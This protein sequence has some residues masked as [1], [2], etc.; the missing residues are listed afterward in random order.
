MVTKM[1]QFEQSYE[2]P[3]AF[4]KWWDNYKVEGNWDKTAQQAVKE[5]F[6]DYH[7]S[8]WKAALG[9]VR[10]LPLHKDGP[11]R[12]KDLIECIEEELGIESYE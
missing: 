9:W 12:P 2:K 5:L 1:E 6:K 10:E 11:S 4:E 3:K 8:G 7:R